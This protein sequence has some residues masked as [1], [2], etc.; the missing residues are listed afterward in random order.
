MCQRTA[1]SRCRG[2]RCGLIS[3]SLSS[4]VKTSMFSCNLSARTDSGMTITPRWTNQ[5][6]TTW[7]TR[8]AVPGTDLPERR[9]GEQVALALR[10]RSSR[11]SVQPLSWTLRRAVPCSTPLPPPLTRREQAGTHSG[12]DETSTSKTLTLTTGGITLLGVLLSVGVSVAF[13]IRADWWVR[14]LAGIATTLALISVVKLGT[15]AGRG[16]LARAARW[17]IGSSKEDRN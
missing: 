13:G 12:M 10:R 14:V 16:P 2:R 15:S 1:S 11:P 7:A 6:R 3:S 9:L 17:T 5:G 8:L 4:Q